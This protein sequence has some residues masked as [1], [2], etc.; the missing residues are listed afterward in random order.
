MQVHIIFNLENM[1]PEYNTLR[2]KMRFDTVFQR[3]DQHNITWLF[4]SIAN[5]VTKIELYFPFIVHLTY[6]YFIWIDASS[7]LY[8]QMKILRQ[9]YIAT[10]P[11]GVFKFSCNFI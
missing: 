11:Q 5:L 8:W 4:L 10:F 7:H 1:W 3:Y 6:G 2:T 9:Q